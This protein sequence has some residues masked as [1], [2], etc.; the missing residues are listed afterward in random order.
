MC[1]LAKYDIAFVTTCVDD[2]HIYDLLDSVY[3]HH[4][5]VR[6]AILLLVQNSIKVNIEKYYVE[7]IDIRVISTNN[8]IPLSVARNILLKEFVLNE[9]DPVIAQYYM[10]P[11]DDTS[12]DDIF[13]MNFKS[14][15][16]SNTLIVVR[17]S[18][19]KDKYFPKL[20]KYEYARKSD[21]NKVLSVS[22]IISWRSLLN[23][24]LFDENL[25]V[26]CYY[27]AG[28]DNDFFLRCNEFEPFR[29]CRGLYTMHPSQG[30]ILQL[31]VE[32]LIKR[33]KSYGRGVIYVLCKHSLYWQALK[34]CLRGYLGSIKNFVLLNFKMMRV[35]FVAANERTKTLFRYIFI[36]K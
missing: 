29:F 22:M 6:C 15:V 11:C 17:A 12:L 33:Y 2:R 32:T 3:E 21:Y 7:E 35:Y 31:P 30:I 14:E 16:V 20:P 19:N 10:F 9:H 13:F 34:V 4:H 28:E 36:K 27:G 24:G 8:I 23:V 18:E 25:G 26:G 1:E 5:D